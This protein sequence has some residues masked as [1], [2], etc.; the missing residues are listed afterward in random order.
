[1]LF[2]MVSFW[3]PR[4]LG[5]ECNRLANRLCLYATIEKIHLI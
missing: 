1:M 5:Y 2:F 4:G 3:K